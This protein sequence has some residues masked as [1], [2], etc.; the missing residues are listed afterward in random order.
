MRIGYCLRCKKDNLRWEDIY[1]R[2]AIQAGAAALKRWCPRCRQWVEPEYREH[3]VALYVERFDEETMAEFK[4]GIGYLAT[5]EQKR[6]LLEWLKKD[7]E[8]S[9]AFERERTRSEG[10]Q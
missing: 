7:V 10:E 2:S 5:L 1:G 6:E 3:K 8:D 4:R 9:E